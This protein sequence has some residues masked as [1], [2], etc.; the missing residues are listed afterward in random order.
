M[1]ILLTQPLSVKTRAGCG[2]I[3]NQAFIN[4]GQAIS[5]CDPI[6]HVIVFKTNID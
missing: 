4:L 6:I 2:R 5:A 3:S 1:I